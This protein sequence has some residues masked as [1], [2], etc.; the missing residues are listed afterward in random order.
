ME[1]ERAREDALVAGI[2]G[3]A[4]VAIALLSSLTGVVSVATLPTL[5]PL[6]V[7]ALY[8]FSR[9]GGPYGSFDTARNW[10]VAAAVV[11]VVVLGASA[12]L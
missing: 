10:A 1:I 3:A 11:G 5:A 2:A 9:K 12:V 7:Y 6:A 8:L 4:T